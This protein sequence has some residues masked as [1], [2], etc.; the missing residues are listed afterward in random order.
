MPKRDS[1]HHQPPESV[2]RLLCAAINN[3]RLI[4]FHYKTCRRI[5]EPHDYGVID[6]MKKLLAYQV[7]GESQSGRLP[8]WRW[9]EMDGINRVTSTTRKVC[10]SATGV[11][12]QPHQVGLS[13]RQCFRPRE[14]PML[15]SPAK[16]EPRSNKV[17][18]SSMTPSAARSQEQYMISVIFPSRHHRYRF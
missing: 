11:F 18:G 17:L 10:G 9:A 6:G 1:L 15:S 7:Q 12:R 13:L 2:H 8:A 3:K 14:G 5:A 4:E 16:P